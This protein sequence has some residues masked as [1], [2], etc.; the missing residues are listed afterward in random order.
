ML[1]EKRKIAAKE[2]NQSNV[3]TQRQ[4]YFKIIASLLMFVIMQRIKLQERNC[5]FLPFFRLFIPTQ[6]KIITMVAT[7]VKYTPPIYI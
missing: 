3:E 2:I 6:K 7:H 4:V 5:T 1:R